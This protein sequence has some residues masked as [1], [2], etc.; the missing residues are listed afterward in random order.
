MSKPIKSPSY[1]KGKQGSMLYEVWLKK[2]G[3]AKAHKLW[4][5]YKL[6]QKKYE[7][8]ETTLRDII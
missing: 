3:Q 1:P 8:K 5:E 2:H 6:T 4:E 7:S